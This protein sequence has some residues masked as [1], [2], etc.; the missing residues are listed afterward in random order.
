M[1]HEVAASS[2]LAT[3]SDWTPA[4]GDVTVSKDGATA[5]NINT[6]PAW[7]ADAKAWKYVF[8]D[9]EL[10]CKVLIVAVRDA[11]LKDD[12]FVVETEN[13]HLSQHPNGVMY[14][15]VPDAFTGTTV[16]LPAAAQT[17]IHPVG[18]IAVV[19]VSTEPLDLGNTALITS[20]VSGTQVAT[21]AD[22]WTRTPTATAANLR[23]LLYANQP[24]KVALTIQGKTDVNAEA[25]AALNT[26]DPP[27]FT[28]LDARTDAI[29]AAL[30]V[31]DD[32]LDTEIGAIKSKTD[33]LPASPAAVGD[34]PTAVQIADALLARHQMGGSNG[35][36]GVRVADALAGGL[37]KI[38]ISG[39]TMTVKHGD[40]STAF[41]RTL[42]RQQLDA[43]TDMV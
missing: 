2:S 12:Q 23:V 35:A 34:I 42:T 26:Y 41:T 22:G 8:S 11:A 24:N 4:S 15:F 31:I 10:Q 37:M 21:M 36:A 13:H 25:T 6:L 33:G 28:E 32:L 19:S 40:G 18:M 9:A 14:S 39:S 27:T 5:A 38:T 1:Q 29:D 16:E 17:E 43:I 30:V 7:D 3:N 20:W